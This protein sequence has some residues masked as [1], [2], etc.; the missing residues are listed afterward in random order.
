[1]KKYVSSHFMRHFEG[2]DES[3]VR[4]LI[5]D[6]IVDYKSAASSAPDGSNSADSQYGLFRTKSPHTPSNTQE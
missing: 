2:A 5:A 4:Q 3:A 1:M 6:F